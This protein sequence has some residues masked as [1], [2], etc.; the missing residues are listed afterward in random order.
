MLSLNV[1]SVL[2]FILQFKI[3][4]PLSQYSVYAGEYVVTVPLTPLAED[5]CIQAACPDVCLTTS[6][7]RAQCAC[8]SDDSNVKAAFGGC[9]GTY[10]NLAI[11]KL[12]LGS[13]LLSPLFTIQLDISYKKKSSLVLQLVLTSTKEGGSRIH[14]LCFY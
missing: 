4:I 13:L 7:G 11:L 3:F 5:P 8:S 2:L 14:S 12:S 10:M 9:V 1:S 6:P